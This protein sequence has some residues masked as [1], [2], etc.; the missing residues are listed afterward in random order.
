MAEIKSTLDLIMERTKN[1]TMTEDERLALQRKEL[2]NKM[3]GWVRRYQEGLIGIETFEVN[4]KSSQADQRLAVEI[5]REEVLRHIDPDQSNKKL[6]QLLS[7]IAG[8][9]TKPI[10]RCLDAYMME[11]ERQ[12][13]EHAEASRHRLEGRGIRGSAVIPNLEKDPGW[14]LWQANAKAEFR[15]S[16]GITDPNNSP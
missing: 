10:T 9:D 11:V 15:K 13:G 3:R 1:L 14:Q 2:Q 8:E 6:F 4:L 7:N 12:R 5:L 16:L